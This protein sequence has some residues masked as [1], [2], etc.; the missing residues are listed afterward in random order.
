MD[1]LLKQIA[2][3]RKLIQGTRESLK[4][5]VENQNAANT[6]RQKSTIRKVADEIYEL[7]VKVQEKRIEQVDSEEDI[8]TW[9]DSV[10]QELETWDDGIANPMKTMNVWKEREDDKTK[11][12]EKE[13]EAKERHDIF[14][15]KLEFDNAKGSKRWNMNCK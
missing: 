11:Q 12:H 7:K 6:E 13:I 5:A 3:K 8:K 4:R 15:Q 9:T 14:K 2:T 10:D 1:E